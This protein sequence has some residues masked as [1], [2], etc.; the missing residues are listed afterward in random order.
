MSKQWVFRDTADEAKVDHLSRAINID[1]VL[2]SI[3]IHRGIQSFDDAK[4]YFRP[5][6]GDLHDPFLMKDMEL[7]VER[8]IKAI[9]YN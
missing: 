1:P 5:Q 9:S 6:L 7:A 8:L 2:S 4:K 3:L